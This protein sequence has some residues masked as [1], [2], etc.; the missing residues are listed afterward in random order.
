MRRNALVPGRR[1][2]LSLLTLCASAAAID[3]QWYAQQD[4]SPASTTSWSDTIVAGGGR[5]MVADESGGAYVSGNFVGDNS[6][7]VGVG[8]TEH[9]GPA[10]IS[11]SQIIVARTT[12]TGT[13]AWSMKPPQLSGQTVQAL[14]SRGTSY[15]SGAKGV[16]VVF[17]SSGYR[18]S[19]ANP[20]GVK[21]MGLGTSCIGEAFPPANTPACSQTPSASWTEF[22]SDG[23]CPAGCMT[24]MGLTAI[25]FVVDT[26][27][28]SSPGT[29]ITGLAVGGRLS[30]GAGAGTTLS[31]VS[32]ACD[33]NNNLFVLG[34]IP[35]SAVF[36]AGSHSVTQGASVGSVLFK[37]ADNGNVEWLIPVGIS[38][39]TI[40]PC[41]VA[42]C[43]LYT[44][45]SPRDS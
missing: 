10:G 11:E 1:T 37:V 2:A 17:A 33:A 40:Y 16:W 34:Q 19:L 14:A 36:Y 27:T 22:Y 23:S 30:D 7:K 26:E 13:F 35:A 38:A 41:G 31:S 43:L 44:S 39:T 28:S 12:A 42:I 18:A 20:T 5:R 21:A 4:P 25:A 8:G 45:P 24:H 15:T 32:A 29:I 3:V 6:M 9:A